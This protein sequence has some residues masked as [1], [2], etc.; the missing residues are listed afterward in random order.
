MSEFLDKQFISDLGF[1]EPN[2]IAYKKDDFEVKYFEN[3]NFYLMFKNGLRW[4]AWQPNS[5]YQAFEVYSHY[6]LAEGHCICT[7]M[8]FLVRE[9]WLLTKKEVTKLTVIEKNKEI[10]DYHNKFNPDIMSQIEVIHSDV[11]DYE[12]ECDTLLIDN[13]EGDVTLFPHWLYSSKVITNKIKSNVMWMWPLESILSS[14]YR[15]YIGLSLSEIYYN[16]KKY[17]DLN[18]LPDLTEEQLFHF[19]YV[20]HR[21][22]FGKCDFT[23]LRS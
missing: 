6:I 21:G 9:K 3:K 18:T 10:I 20:H 17:F 23:K 8:G 15:N 4:M 11:Y 7:G 16:I 2:V 14:C 12:G 13:F 1:I 22:N 19:C 5:F